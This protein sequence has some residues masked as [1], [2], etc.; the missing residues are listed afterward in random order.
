[1]TEFKKGDWV[2]N[3]HG[4]VCKLKYIYDRSELTKNVRLADGVSWY[5]LV[6]VYL[7]RSRIATA[8]E[9]KL[10]KASKEHPFRV[11]AK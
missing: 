4:H 2:V 6:S 1:M 10:H 5:G 7:D 11:V 8:E 9:V 3:E